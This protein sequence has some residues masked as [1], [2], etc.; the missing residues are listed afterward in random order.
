MKR[1]WQRIY[2]GGERRHLI[3]KDLAIRFPCS[4]L[5]DRQLQRIGYR[6]LKVSKSDLLSSWLTGDRNKVGPMATNIAAA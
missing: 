1:V 6:P 4:R 2:I 3:R 5:L